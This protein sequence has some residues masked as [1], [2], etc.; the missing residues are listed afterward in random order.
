V[1]GTCTLAK[2][3]KMRDHRH[4]L[5]RSAHG[6]REAGTVVRTVGQKR[7]RIFGLAALVATLAA[8]TA[9]AVAIAER[10]DIERVVV[11]RDDV[12]VITFRI[13]FGSPVIVDPADNIQVA[14]DAD[15]DSG[16]GVNGLDYSLDQTGPLSFGANRAALLTAVDGERVVS[17]PRTLRFSRKAAG[18]GFSSSSV[19]FSVPAS[20]IGD[21]RRF[22][23]YVFIRMEGELDEAPSHVLFS[24]GAAPWT[25]PKDGEPALGEAYPVE[26]YEDGSDFTLS[27]RGGV[28][29]SVV[30]GVVLGIGALVAVVGW[31]VYRLSARRKMRSL[32]NG[33]PVSAE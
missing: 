5:R 29:L 27:E 12:G 1:S 2:G 7:A 9:P 19:A 18:Y 10:P 26:T 25:Y 20:V 16:T 14:I 23:F 8:L 33:D 28:F 32:P 13:F 11:G 22:D 24:A 17:H 3:G 4:F 30:G 6:R 21:P 15:R 31:G